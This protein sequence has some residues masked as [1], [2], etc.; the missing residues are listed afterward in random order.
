MLNWKGG[1]RAG[2]ATSGDDVRGFLRKSQSLSTCLHTEGC[3]L[4]NTE[5][6]SPGSE[7]GG[8]RKKSFRCWG[9]KLLTHKKLDPQRFLLG[10]KQL[11]C[12]VLC[13]AE[14]RSLS[15]TAN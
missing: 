7:E 6:Q 4:R 11:H 1:G 10:F 9:R 14:D 3:S 8:R 13:W 5:P 12:L 15:V 2:R